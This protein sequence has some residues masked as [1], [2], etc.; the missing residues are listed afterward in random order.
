MFVGSVMFSLCVFVLT[1]IP[2]TKQIH[3][4]VILMCLRGSAKHLQLTKA[5]VILT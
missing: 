3:I 4:L 5:S 1:I 2:P